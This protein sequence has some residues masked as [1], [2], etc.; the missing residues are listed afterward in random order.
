[1]EARERLGGRLLRRRLAGID[2][3]VELGGAWFST[4]E[5]EPLRRELERYGIAT[6]TTE[7]ASAHRWLTGGR[8]RQG[9]PIPPDEAR[10]FERA[11]YELGAASRR[12]PASVALDGGGELADL[13]LSAAAWIERLRLPAATA[14]LLS[15]FAAMYGGCDPH[16]EALLAHL[17]DVAGFG[18]S[19]FA[20]LDGLAEELAD[21]STELIGRLA[22]DCGA[23]IRMATPVADVEQTRDGVR[24]TTTDGER[25]E[26]AVGVLAV[27]INVLATIALGPEPDPLIAAAA[28]RGQPCRS[29]KLWLLAEGVPAGL[30]AAGW[31]AP[32]QWL[33]SIRE[34]D[35]AQ[36]MVAFG[37]PRPSFDPDS[38]ESVTEAVQRL[39]PGARVLA[40]DRHDWNADPYSRGAWGMWRPGWVSDGTLRAFNALHGALAFAGSD[41]APQWPGW[42]AGAISSGARAAGLVGDHLG[43]ASV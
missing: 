18:H 34:L 28:R 35:G 6:R 40:I 29:I 38:L 25:Y 15:A 19:A 16:E 27:P 3:E 22:A 10:A 9:A 37:H 43:A 20:L 4:A 39:A 5:M 17:A 33:S 11:L 21:G 14:D 2:A 8:T 41:F 42:I 1:L 31:P 36:L 26:A 32:L 13:D 24:A 7:P 12:L 23:V 30:L